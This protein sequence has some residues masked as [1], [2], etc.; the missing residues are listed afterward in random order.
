MKATTTV[1]AAALFA[2]PLQA[3]ETEKHD[4]PIEELDTDTVLRS[5]LTHAIER[6]KR[7]PWHEKRGEVVHWE[8]CRKS[9]GGCAVHIE[10]IVDYIVDASEAHE[11]DPYVLASIVWTESR[12]QPYA[13][14]KAGEMGIVQIHPSN[15]HGL[16]WMRKGREGERY[17]KTCRKQVGQCQHEVAQHGAGILSRYAARC[18][19]IEGGLAAY[20]TGRCDSTAGAKYATRVLRLAGDLRH[21]VEGGSA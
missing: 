20:N 8:V 13:T 9:P 21:E 1:L 7:I 17:R 11:V 12:Y 19:S 2:G 3:A 6:R 18:G 4:T 15:R 14:G 10:A 16:Q 5:G